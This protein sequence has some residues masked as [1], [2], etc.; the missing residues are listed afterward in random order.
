MLKYGKLWFKILVLSVL[1]LTTLGVI[2]HVTLGESNTVLTAS[3]NGEITKATQIMVE[4]L[5]QAAET[6][7]ARLVI[8]KANTPGGELGAVQKIMDL[9]VVSKVPTCVFVYPTGGSAWS[10]GTYILLAAHVAAMA[11]GTTI[12]SCQPVFPT[13]QVVESPKYLNAYSSLLKHHARLHSRNETAAELFVT[14]N[15]NLGPEEALRYHVIELIADDVG[16][17][18]RELESMSLVRFETENKTLVWKLVPSDEAGS[19]SYVEKISFEEVA[20]ARVEEYQ[21]GLKF[22][23]LS[24]LLNPL[25]SSLLLVIGIFS[26][27]IGI[28][29]P[30]YGAEIAGALCIFLALVAFGIIGIAPAAVLFF[31]LGAALIVAELKTNVGALA[32]GGAVCIVVGSLLLFPSSRWLLYWETAREI[33]IWL[34]GTAIVTA[35]IFSFVVYK[36]AETKKLK[37]RTGAEALLGARGIAAMDL[38]PKGQV[39]VLGEFWQAVTLDRPICKGE[40]VEVVRKEGL[41]LFVKPVNEKV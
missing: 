26:L 24:I 13:G 29:T 36:V 27:L 9:L 21:P 40:V 20:N 17:L 28:K 1:A 16:V 41:T 3:I 25:V 15:L 34:V 35:A 11:S 30:G 31:V 6:T 37:P 23:F 14:E 39:R 5:V 32:L 2:P 19:Y 4:D 33:Q 38:K 8:L 22:L 18:L 12:G 7:N 10:G